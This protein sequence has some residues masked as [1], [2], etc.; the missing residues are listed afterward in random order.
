VAGPANPSGVPFG[1]LSGTNVPQFSGVSSFADAGTNAFY[2]PTGAVPFAVTAMFRGNPADD[3]VQ[4]IVGRSSD[5]WRIAMTTNGTLQCTLGT[6]S[7]SAVTSVGVYNDGNWHQVVAVYTP[8]SVPTVTGTNALYVDGVLDT[9]VSTVSTNGIGPGSA[10]DMMIGADPQYT[11]TPAGIGQQ[12]A[13]QVCEVAIFNSALTATQ[14]QAIYNAAILPTISVTGSDNN[15]TITYV[16]TLLSS[17]NVTGPYTTNSVGGASSPYTTPATN[18]Q[19]F[20]RSSS[21]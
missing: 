16:G 9:S 12:F 5:S 7:V 6:N 19:Q 14:I 17:T 10:M 1:G 20:Y 4:T 18:A 2:N 8:A 21:P 3:R 13:G 11:N 15:V